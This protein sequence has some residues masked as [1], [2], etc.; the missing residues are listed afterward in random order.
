MLI[1]EKPAWMVAE[2]SK[3]LHGPPIVKKTGCVIGEC[4][5]EL[6]HAPYMYCSLHYTL[7]LHN[8]EMFLMIICKVKKWSCQQIMPCQR[9]IAIVVSY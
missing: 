6:L 3:C 8:K 1:R 9:N 7:C 2:L 4:M 5:H